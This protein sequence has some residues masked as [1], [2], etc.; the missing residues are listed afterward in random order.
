[1]KKILLLIMVACTL[2]LIAQ[3]PIHE[4]N[5]NGTLSNTK[6]TLTFDG[7]P[8]YVTNKAGIANKAQRLAHSY[9]EVSIGDL[10]LANRARTVSIWIKYNDISIANYM[11][12]YG[13]SQNA[14]Y[15]GL[16]Q[17]ST[18]GAKSDLNLAGWG[19]INDAIVPTDIALNTWYNY[20][21]TY[22]GVSS[23]IYRNGQLLKSSISSKKYTS[24]ILFS[25][26][27]MGSLV[28]INADVDDLKIYDVALTAAE[29]SALY[30]SSSVLPPNDIAVATTKTKTSGKKIVS[31]APKTAVASTISVNSNILLVAPPENSSSK[32]TEIFSTKGEKVITPLQL[33]KSIL[34]TCP[35]ALIC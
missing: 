29:V 6:N 2:P 33:R 25:L 18:T 14:Q 34:V 3:I 28:S 30:N 11:W 1:M 24:N 7:V 23:N 10:P 9:M 20:T 5:F 17:Q 15:F 35:K 8:N 4:F 13:S 21:A 32:L 19:P 26:G 12:G 27:K 22:D 16:L 31:K